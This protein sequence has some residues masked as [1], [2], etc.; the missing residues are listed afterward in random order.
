MKKVLI[1]EDDRTEFIKLKNKFIQAG[2]WTV[3][4]DNYE[5]FQPYFNKG[6]RDQLVKIVIELAESNAKDLGA[7]VLDLK[8]VDISHDDTGVNILKSLRDL[9]QP[10]EKIDYWKWWTRMPIII[11]SV[12]DNDTIKEK[13]MTSQFS[14]HAYITKD[15]SHQISYQ[16]D[17]VYACV[18]LYTVFKLGRGMNG[19]I[20]YLDRKQIEQQDLYMAEFEG[21]KQKFQGD[22]DEIKKFLHEIM[23]GTWYLM[24]HDQRDIFL[25]E[26]QE[27]IKKIAGSKEKYEQLNQEVKD[28]KGKDILTCIKES[29]EE[30]DFSS[31]LDLIAEFLGDTSNMPQLCV[32][33]LSATLKIIAN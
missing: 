5:Q 25:H 9:P 11:C 29:Y 21:F 16:N 10:E 24:N 28:A 22:F 2:G 6:K 20:D 12:Y 13:V 8:L 14:A 33:A 31:A 26:H 23:W 19:L 17:V 1:V 15:T 27:I 7:I 18:A 30:G 3:I 32:K 4:P